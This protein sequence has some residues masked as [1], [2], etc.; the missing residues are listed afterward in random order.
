MC[1]ASISI[2][3][4]STDVIINDVQYFT[5]KNTTKTLINIDMSALPISVMII[6]VVSKTILF[7]LGNET[8]PYTFIV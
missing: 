6:T 7:V 1:A 4:E 8:H 2:V 5:E 3:Y